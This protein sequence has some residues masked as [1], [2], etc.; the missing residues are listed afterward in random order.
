MRESL[1]DDGHLALPEVARRCVALGFMPKRTP[2][3][4]SHRRFVAGFETVVLFLA[5]LLYSSEALEA[6]YQSQQ[7]SI[8]DVH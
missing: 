5:V 6:T 1:E 4:C 3:P 2:F 7:T 8:K